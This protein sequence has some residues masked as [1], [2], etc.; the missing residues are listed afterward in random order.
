MKVLLIGGPR[1]GVIKEVESSIKHVQF[2][3][4]SQGSELLT[5]DVRDYNYAGQ[6]YKVAWPQDFLPSHETICAAIREAY[7]LLATVTI[8]ADGYVSGF[9]ATRNASFTIHVD[10]DTARMLNTARKQNSLPFGERRDDEARRK[11][12]DWHDALHKQIAAFDEANR[13]SELHRLILK[14]KE[15]SLLVPTH[16]FVTKELRDFIFEYGEKMSPFFVA[17]NDGEYFMGMKLVIVAEGEL[18]VGIMR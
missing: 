14:K 18:S 15:E 6:E 12:R 5:Y 7:P 16:L 13:F 4:A 8:D 11:S 17:K 9:K 10:A 2:P 3:H 1:H